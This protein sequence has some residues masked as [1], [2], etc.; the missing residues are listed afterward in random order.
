MIFELRIFPWE[1]HTHIQNSNCHP[2]LPTNQVNDFQKNKTKKNMKLTILVHKIPLSPL[3]LIV[4]VFHP[5][6]HFAG[7][8][9]PPLPTPSM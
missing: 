5:N 1:T 4:F 6:P 9:P 8:L 7:K 2:S 3:S